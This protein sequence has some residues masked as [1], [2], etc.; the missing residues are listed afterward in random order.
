MWCSTTFINNMVESA[1]AV[2]N[3]IK[4]YIETTMVYN[5][6]TFLNIAIGRLTI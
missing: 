5:T 4:N 1:L 2:E 3:Q 6:D